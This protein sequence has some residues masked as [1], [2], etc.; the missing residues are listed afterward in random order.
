[1]EYRYGLMTVQWDDEDR[2]LVLIDQRRLPNRLEYIRCRSHEQVAECIRSMAVRGAPAIGVAAAFGLALAAINSRARDRES[3]MREMD[4]AFR[5]LRSTRPTAI[6]L[7]W[8]LERVMGKGRSAGS[9]EEAKVSMLSEAITMLK[10]DLDVNRRLGDHGSSLLNDGDRVLTHCNA[11]ALATV[12]YGTALGV[13][14]AAREKGKRISVIAAETRPVMQGARLTAFELK[15]DGI[16]VSIAPDTSIGLLM[17]RGMIDKVIVGADR[18][19]RDGHVFN[20]IGTYQV[21][22]LA[23]EHSIP[24]YVAAPLSSF[25]LKSRVDEVTIEERAY[26]E[27]VKVSGKRVAPRGVRVFNPAFDI[28]PPH[29]ITAI[30]T[31]K[32]VL[33]QPYEQSIARVFNPS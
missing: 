33:E 13:I 15:H 2:S 8:A 11:G 12:G 9:V 31:E 21:A 6:N 26:D 28:T 16:D 4:A 27:V 29:L 7:F 18:V 5:L 17:A 19:L 25:D 32:G 30:V 10:E 24:F 1:M 3:F 23:R 20:K 22:I 14:R